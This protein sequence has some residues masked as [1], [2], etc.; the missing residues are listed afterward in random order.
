MT[1]RLPPT[2]VKMTNLT[3][4]VENDTSKA[5]DLLREIK[6]ASGECLK[7]IRVLNQRVKDGKAANSNDK[8]SVLSLIIVASL[9]LKLSPHC[10]YYMF[11]KL[12]N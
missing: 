6:K 12:M 2:A 3:D 4:I 9:S 7:N 1:S 11:Y 5:V 10:L 8:V